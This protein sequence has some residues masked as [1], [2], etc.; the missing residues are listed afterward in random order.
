MTPEESGSTGERLARLEVLVP[1]LRDDIKELKATIGE[2]RTQ[3]AEL[4]KAA[5]MGKG[6]LW[7][8]LP[9]GTMVGWLISEGLKWVRHT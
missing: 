6:V 7:I 8:L 5:H 2:L 3:T 4:T 1:E 9:L